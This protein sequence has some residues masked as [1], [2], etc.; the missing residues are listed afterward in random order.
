MEMEGGRQRVTGITADGDKIII[1]GEQDFL[2]QSIP[3]NKPFGE[4]VASDEHPS[5][6]K[7]VPN[8]ET[9]ASFE[10][11]A[12]PEQQL[13]FANFIQAVQGDPRYANALRDQISGGTGTLTGTQLNDLIKN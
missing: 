1:N 5:G 10:Q 11:N 6:F 13:M 7:F 4:F 8:S 3:G 9:W 12:S 2:G